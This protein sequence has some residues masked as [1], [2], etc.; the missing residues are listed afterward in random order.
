MLVVMPFG[1]GF[2]EFWKVGDGASLC[3]GYFDTK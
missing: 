1:C 3:Y 2:D